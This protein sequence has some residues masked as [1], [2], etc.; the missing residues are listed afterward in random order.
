MSADTTDTTPTT[1]AVDPLATLRAERDHYLEGF[2]ALRRGTQA[3]L[4]AVKARD[5][6]KATAVAAEMTETEAARKRL[7][8]DRDG[9]IRA[10]G[11]AV[12][13]LS[14]SLYEWLDALGAENNCQW[15]FSNKTDPQGRE[16]TVTAQWSHG[17]TPM[18]MRAAALAEVERL[19]AAL[20][21]AERRHHEHGAFIQLG[22]FRVGID[23]AAAWLDQRAAALDAR[24]AHL[25]PNPNGFPADIHYNLVED[26]RESAAQARLDAK[27]I[28]DLPPPASFPDAAL[29][30][31]ARLRAQHDEQVSELR[32]QRDASHR[33][34][35]ALRRA[36][37]GS[38]V[39]PAGW[40]VAVIEGGG[41]YAEAREAAGLSVGQATQVTAIDRDRLRAIEAGDATPTDAELARLRE[42]YD[43]A[44]FVGATR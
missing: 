17:K 10:T 41:T 9:T 42:T 39:P 32:A 19:R 15:R 43:V 37:E 28:R 6:L 20:A 22:G 29:L 5:W 8:L 12:D 2:E 38:T 16:L 23:T 21:E 26:F 14:Q 11:W 13:L 31:D 35:E 3:L 4:D 25:E 34:E 27:T 18:E 36:A 24:C 33:R 30:A 7:V 40:E 1:G 44:G